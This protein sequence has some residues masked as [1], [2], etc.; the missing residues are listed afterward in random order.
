MSEPVAL[1]VHLLDVNVVSQAV[2]L[3]KAERMSSLYLVITT[4]VAITTK[5]RAIMPN[6]F[7]I[8]GS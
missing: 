4:A 5:T 2:Q 3:V 8:Q 6:G 1:A 7:I